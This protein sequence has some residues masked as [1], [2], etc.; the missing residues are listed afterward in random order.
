MK[1][2]IKDNKD[3]LYLQISDIIFIFQHELEL[4]ESVKQDFNEKLKIKT[5][6][7]LEDNPYTFKLFTEPETIEFINNLSYIVDYNEYKQLS[8]PEI[9]EQAY[10]L[11]D[12]KQELAVSFNK[13]SLKD[14][15]KKQDVVD[16]CD[17]LDFTILSLRDL[18]WFKEGAISMIIPGS[19]RAKKTEKKLLKK[20]NLNI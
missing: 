20:N 3:K 1:L 6:R 14:R 10:L 12:K 5:T 19:K 13:L 15:E 7:G 9:Y 16:L 2:L 17:E 8:V 11:Q 4:P 18:V